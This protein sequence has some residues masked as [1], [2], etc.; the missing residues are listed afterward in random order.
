MGNMVNSWLTWE[1]TQT[2]DAGVDLS[3]LDSRFT[4]TFDFYNRLTNNSFYARPVSYILSIL[5]SIPHLKL[6]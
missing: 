6:I 5:L 4:L 2:W 3:F 1:K